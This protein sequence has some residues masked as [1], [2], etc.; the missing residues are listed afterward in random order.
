MSEQELKPTIA[1]GLIEYLQATGGGWSMKLTMERLAFAR[2][3]A[4]LTAENG[5]LESRIA[6]AVVDFSLERCPKCERLTYPGHVCYGCGC[7]PSEPR[8]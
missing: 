1:E 7:D 4:T 3:I 5:R 8:P 6:T 2:I